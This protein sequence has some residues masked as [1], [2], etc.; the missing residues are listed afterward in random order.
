MKKLTYFGA[1]LIASILVLCGCGSTMTLAEKEEK[2][3]EI[4]NAVEMS[5]FTFKANHAHP[6][7]FKSQ[8]LSPNYDVVVSSDTIKVY[9]P[10]FGRAY[11]AP[12]DPRDGGYRFTS[13]DFTYN[14]VE[15]KKSGNWL[16]DISFNDLGRNVEFHFDI[17]ENGSASLR[18]NDTDRQGISYQGDVVTD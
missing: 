12:M 10:Y 14:V 7:G 13:T 18:V 15:G 2:A 3:V 5:D 17:F 8:Y 16:V 1:F 4:R 11:R 6:S 9:L